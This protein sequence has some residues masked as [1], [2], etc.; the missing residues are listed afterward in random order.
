MELKD[1]A[2]LE[3]AVRTARQF[4]REVFLGVLSVSAAWLTL[5]GEQK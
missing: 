5:K 2:P 1:K 4:S 3:G